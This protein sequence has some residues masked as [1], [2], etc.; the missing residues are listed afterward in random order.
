MIMKKNVVKINENTLRQIVAESVKKVLNE[1]IET[2]PYGQPIY[3]PRPPKGSNNGIEGYP[4]LRRMP[5]DLGKHPVVKNQWKNGYYDINSPIVTLDDV[6]FEYLKDMVER[7]NAMKPQ[8]DGYH[9][10]D[11]AWLEYWQDT[12]NKYFQS[13]Q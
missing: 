1:A 13:R 4:D 9:G 5:K 11:D 3:S 6:P 12:L 2:G 8:K 7:F 10:A